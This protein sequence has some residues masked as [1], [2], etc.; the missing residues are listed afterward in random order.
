M[1]AGSMPR[2]V[3][4]AEGGAESGS[5]FS[6][7]PPLDFAAFSAAFSAALAA[8]P[9]L[10][11]SGGFGASGGLVGP[12]ALITL[13]A[14]APSGGGCAGAVA[15]AAAAPVAGPAPAEAPAPAPVAD[16]APPAWRAAAGRVDA[17]G[18]K[19]SSSDTDKAARFTRTSS[20]RGGRFVG[21]RW[22][23]SGIPPP[24]ARE[25]GVGRQAQ[26]HQPQPPQRFR[27]LLVQRVADQQ[28]ACQDE[29][30]RHHRVPPGAIG[31]RGVRD[32]KSVV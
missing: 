27:R 14:S 13:S 31:A 20:T 7:V 32:R 5:F 25:G 28:Q 16:P 30:R 3:R 6:S 18:S 21:C 1:N 17:G 12:P 29:Q 2:R 15:P 8:L 24:A 10:P 22:S 9:P 11:D 19:H 26:G 23:V 4:A